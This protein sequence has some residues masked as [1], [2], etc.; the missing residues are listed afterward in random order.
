MSFF[1]RCRTLHTGTLFQILRDNM[2]NIKEPTYKD[3]SN[4]PTNNPVYTGDHSYIYSVKWSAF[5]GDKEKY[6]Q[7]AEERKEKIDDYN[8]TKVVD[9]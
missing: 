1:C 9:D 8:I 5:I 7:M 6:L 4:H 3:C 2:F